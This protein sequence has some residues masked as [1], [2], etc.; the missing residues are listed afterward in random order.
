MNFIFWKFKLKSKKCFNKDKK[1]EVLLRKLISL[2]IKFK[3]K[4]RIN[5]KNE[6]NWKLGYRFK[7]KLNH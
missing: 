5:M 2:R 3:F 7:F 6:K 4:M 1:T